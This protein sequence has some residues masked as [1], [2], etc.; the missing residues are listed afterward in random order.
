V[1]LRSLRQCLS[2]LAFTFLSTACLAQ[3][4]ALSNGGNQTGS[5][6]PSHTDSWT[7]TVPANTYWHGTLSLPTISG[8]NFLVHVIR[9][10][11]SHVDNLGTNLTS[12]GGTPP[13]GGD[14]YT[15]QVQRT[16]SISGNEGYTI[17]AA[18]APASSFVMNDDNEGGA[19][20]N[21][22][23]VFGS[24]T[25]G[26]LDVYWFDA[27]ASD[28]GMS[29]EVNYSGSF[30]GVALVDSTGHT[31]TNCPAG[32]T[33]Q[34]FCNITGNAAGKIYVMVVP[35]S[36][37]VQAY[38]LTLHNATATLSGEPQKSYGK[39][40]C[41]CAND[42]T[43]EP[44]SGMAAA[45]EP[46][47]I[48][49][50]NM[51]DSFVDYTTAGQNPLALIR[52]YNSGPSAGTFAV[53][54]GSNWR[55][56]Y[57]RYLDLV[58]STFVTAE[59]PDGQVLNFRLVSSVWKPDTDSDYRLTNSGSTWTLIDHDD[60][61]ETYTAIS[62][63]EAQLNS[64]AT[65]AGY[66]QTLAYSGSQLST[67]TDSYSRVLTFSYTG[68]TLT[69]VTTPDS[70]TLTYGFDTVG[71]ASRLISV[72]YNTTPATS[73]AYLYENAS[74]PFAMTGI[75]DE[76]GAR[77]ATWGYDTQG[78]AN[79]SQLAG[80][81][82][83]TSITFAAD[84]LSSVVTNPLGLQ[85]TYKFHGLQGVMKIVEIDRHDPSSSVPDASQTFTYDSNGYLNKHTDWNG[86]VTQYTNNVYG[87]PTQMLEAVGS[88]V[89]RTTN[90]TY[91]T[92]WVRKAKTIARSTLTTGHTFDATAGTTLTTTYTDTS[93]IHGTYAPTALTWTYTYNST[94]QLLTVTAPRTD[95]TVTTT[96]AYTGGTLT[97]ITKPLSQVT[98]INTYT[99]GGRPLTMTDPNSVVTTLTWS[100][101]NWLLTSSVGTTGGARTTTYGYDSAGNLT[102]V[103]QPGGATLTY[104][105]DNAH[106]LTTITDLFS[107][108]TN[109]TLD[110]NGDITATTLKDGSGTTKF[111]DGNTF[112]ALGRRLTHTGGASQVTQY[113]Y[114][115]N[116][117]MTSI[118]D[119]LVHSA[120][121]QTFDA[122]NRVSQITD[123]ASGLTKYTYDAY[124]MPLTVQT[125]NG[126]TTGYIY[127]GL[128][129]LAKENSPDRGG[130]FYYHDGDA[131]LTKTVDALS[132][133]S[134][135][136]YDALDRRTAAS[137][138]ASSTE[139]VAY[140][141]DQTGHG[142][143]IGRLTSMT[144][145]AGTF[146]RSYDE[147]GNITSEGHTHSTYTLTNGYAY[148]AA[149]L[150]TSLTY[151]SGMILTQTRDTMERIT[152]LSLKPT[153][154]G[155]SQTVLSSITYKPFGPVA[156]FS[157]GNGVTDT[158][159]LDADYRVTNVTDAGTATLQN[160]TYT[161]NAND[162]PTGITDAV[163]SG[164][165]QTLT[166]DSL[167]RLLTAAGGYGSE[168]FGYDANGNR[169]STN[170]V[171]NSYTANTNKLTKIG[172][173]TQ[174]VT[175][176]SN[177]NIT[178]IAYATAA[179]FTYNNANRLAT[180]T[181]GGGTVLSYL[182]DGFG[183]RV[184]KTDL[185]QRFQAY[186]QAGRYIEQTDN[187]VTSIQDYV[188]L[189]GLPV[190]TFIPNGGTGTL[191][192][193]HTDR[194]GTP[195]LATNA[196]QT[197]GWSNLATDPFNA[198]NAGTTTTISNDLR[199]PG[200]EYESSAS[201]NHNGFRDYAPSLGR[202]LESDPIGLNGGQASTYAYVGSNP[203]RF[204]DPSGLADTNVVSPKDPAFKPSKAY[205]NPK[206]WTVAGHGSPSDPNHI[207]TA[208]KDG[209]PLSV[210][211]VGDDILGGHWNGGKPIQTLVCYATKGGNQSFDAQLAQYLA[212]KTGI[213][214][215]IYGSPNIVRVDFDDSTGQVTQ[216]D[217]GSGGWQTITAYPH[218]PV[219]PYSIY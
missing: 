14:S 108:T 11:D 141:Y 97:S 85:E 129:W 159:T 98:T 57:D 35:T 128:E 5:I 47:N 164:N 28:P 27:G 4:G 45:G 10:S 212:N 26:D 137:Y 6:G 88:T 135:Y 166:Y 192:F 89:A 119:P 103:A 73:Q 204:V 12:F 20:F 114:D 113:A 96:Y 118:I 149:G 116:S 99:S 48:T 8:E 65:K 150:V 40:A 127:N 143:G 146:S 117:N 106:R 153:S 74:F 182:Y 187:T 111:S 49:N 186:D 39:I 16:D 102:S 132:I 181:L 38:S 203:G 191:S 144:D 200:Q 33:G 42:P 71:S 76:N 211:Q 172:T 55:T 107:Q 168:S 61:T 86:N 152:G 197:I 43:A 109:Y 189:G 206:F 196:S 82:G 133:T 195:R 167:D 24:V 165:S 17:T 29:V 92:T 63:S 134:N 178:N 122:L 130:T 2:L 162:N 177:G 75:T 87:L 169:N 81:A 72:G 25:P 13:T 151:P 84:G 214:V 218:T 123:R 161:L 36:S 31:S 95:V 32:G 52:H 105:Y 93:G 94:G 44:A 147:R 60:T 80:G 219:N 112:D 180:A 209:A 3:G 131:N 46:I 179:G 194:L 18:V 154:G 9:N 50:G 202:Y 139:N 158:R 59:R 110:A 79:S 121:T 21:E 148:D 19:I 68:T 54:L 201:S 90:I 183:Q 210:A 157:Y 216:V 170:G 115:A 34:A 78:R 136:T 176:N 101:R 145:Q 163:T 185:A 205:K 51:F 188:Y 215:T 30:P 64:I 41:N 58:S 37:V 126:A 217:P 77:Y 140:T 91:D 142:F 184:T 213:P 193:L 171:A 66:T 83:A 69:G 56:N 67:V 62:G 155:T 208:T 22:G 100:P 199:M 104:G 1:L 138:P 15:V 174:T 23:T 120:T 198:P 190:A 53:S 156:G 207:Y 175:T 124:D 173:G 125:P 7:I 160:L 70:L